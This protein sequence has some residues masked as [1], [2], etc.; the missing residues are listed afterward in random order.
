MSPKPTTIRWTDDDCA[1]L[2]KLQA[3]TGLAE[4]AAAVRFAIRHAL[5]TLP[6][7]MK[8]KKQGTA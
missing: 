4:T 2:A 3:A 7:T 6:R 1:I 8:L 5:A